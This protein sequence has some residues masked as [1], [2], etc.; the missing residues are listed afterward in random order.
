M[1]VEHTLYENLTFSEQRKL[2]DLIIR[3]LN[4]ENQA[5]AELAHFDC[6]GAAGCYDLGF[7]VTQI[8]YKMGESKFA[9]MLSRLSDESAREVEVLIS[10]GLEYGD[11]DQNEKTDNTTIERAFPQL[12]RQIKARPR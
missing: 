9:E 12:L 2:K 3:T 8:I 5:L 11:N 7:V 4:R 10:V 1:K 6:G